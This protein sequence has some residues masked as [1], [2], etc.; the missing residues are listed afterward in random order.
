M[1][2]KFQ[3]ALRGY[4][5]PI[6]KRDGFKCRYCD[7][8]GS[9]WPNWL[10]LSW[11]HLLPIGDPQRDNQDYIVAA[12]RFC[13]EVHNRTEFDVKDKT[14]DEL[15]KQ[16]KFFVSRKRDEYKL[17]WGKEVKSEA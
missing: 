11:D 10:F 16:K 3:D 2:K 13:N 4:A 17:F 1:S 12:C 7:F 6:L 5:H 8:D 15:V 9:A 14:P